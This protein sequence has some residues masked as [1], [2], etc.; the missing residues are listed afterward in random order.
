[1]TQTPVG[2]A[3]PAPNGVAVMDVGTRSQFVVSVQVT[4]E[5]VIVSVGF[6]EVVR[7]DSQWIEQP[8]GAFDLQIFH[9]ELATSPLTVT[10]V[11]PV[12]HLAHVIDAAVA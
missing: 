11:L 2:T 8:I 12:G 3:E 10:W 1:M 9:V 6:T 4:H 7:V 5:K